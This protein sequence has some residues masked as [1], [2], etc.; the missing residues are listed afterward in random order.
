MA[1]WFKQD[2]TGIS[3]GGEFFPAEK[4]VVTVPDNVGGLQEYG[5]ERRF[6]EEDEKAAEE[7]A[8]L[9]EAQAA[10]VA[11]QEADKKAAEEEAAKKAAEEAAKTG[12]KGSK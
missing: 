4:G 9:A 6:T 8:K 7:A 1:K 10:E 11:K 3:I 2:A 5:F 12:N